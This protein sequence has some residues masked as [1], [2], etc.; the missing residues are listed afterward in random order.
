[1]FQ[2]LKTV[3]QSFGICLCLL[4]GS[5]VSIH[6]AHAVSITPA[7]I[8]ASAAPGEIAS[9][10]ITVLNDEQEPRAILPT[11]QK[12]IPLGTDGRQ[13]FLPAEDV[14]GLPSW[15]LIDTTNLILQPGER[16]PV[17][18]RVQV[19]AE[20][21]PGGRYQAVFF[22]SVPVGQGAQANVGFQARIGALV[23]FTVKGDVPT[24]LTIARFAL[25]D[26]GTQTNLSGSASVKIHNDGMG[27]VVPEGF[28]VIRNWFGRVV[29]RYPINADNKRVLPASDR[30][31]QAKF[32]DQAK[33]EGWVGSTLDEITN[34]G[35]GRYTFTI[36]G[37][38]HQSAT[39]P[40]IGIFILPWHLGVTAL[41]FL[42]AVLLIL[43]L[44]RARLIRAM[45]VQ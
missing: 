2:G 38:Q 23:F 41:A 36:E 1:M 10:S 33:R 40:A 6:S 34:F 17:N 25:A 4:A 8:E 43:R 44:Y 12:F 3:I 24:R 20:A 19:P 18:I 26:T 7:L 42:A 22:S 30:E 11:I 16:R 9:F 45:R 5:A 29:A 14:S 13:Q 35:L 28:L 32:G 27:H 31:L 21:V 15:T 39:V 37:V